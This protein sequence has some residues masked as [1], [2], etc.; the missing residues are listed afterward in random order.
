MAIRLLASRLPA[1]YAAMELAERSGLSLRQAYRYVQR[2][3]LCA[4]PLVVPE[5]KSV[6]TV[7]L[8]KG[9]IRKVRQRARQQKQP[10]S[11]WVS[12]ALGTFLETGTG[13]G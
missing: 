3:G 11:G 12:Q 6:F 13:H 7:K 2:A 5:A 9:L 4:Q 8:P 1:G 10:I